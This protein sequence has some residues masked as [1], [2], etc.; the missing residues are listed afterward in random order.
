MSMKLTLSISERNVNTVSG[1]KKQIVFAVVD[2]DRSE[3]YPQNFVCLLPKRLDKGNKPQSKFLEIFGEKGSQIAVELLKNAL[4]SEHDFEV[5][6]EIEERLSIFEPNE[7]T[8]RC[9]ACGCVFEPVR[10]RRFIQRLCQKCRD[11]KYNR[12]D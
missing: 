3:N 6:R 2:L 5:R 8:A 11:K 4:S 12:A 7:V 10:R 9:V 1:P